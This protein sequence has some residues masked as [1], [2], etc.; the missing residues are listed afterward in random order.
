MDFDLNLSEEAAEEASVMK[1][2]INEWFDTTNLQPK[3]ESNPN[4]KK[5]LL[6]ND[7]YIHRFLTAQNYDYDKAMNTLR[8]AIEWRLTFQ[9]VGIET[10]ATDSF[11]NVMDML[12][13][14]Y[15]GHDQFNRPV[16]F[17]NFKHW[18]RCHRNMEE[19]HRCCAYMM[20]RVEEFLRPPTYQVVVIFD[21]D[22]FSI[23]NLDYPLLHFV[24]QIQHFYPDHLATA[25]I[26]RAPW[27][28]STTWKCI[29]KLIDPN[30]L[31]KIDFVDVSKLQCL[32]PGVYQQLEDLLKENNLERSCC[33]KQVI[34]RLM[35]NKITSS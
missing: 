30:T 24:V 19:A 3:L 31:S 34:H 13:L 33:V 1:K 11:E 26:I 28:F 17:L 2:E 23:K 10:V 32:G 7:S 6:E 29:K 22:E 18:S 8:S 5:L 4:T 9:G 25:Y 12:L 16:F 20:N 15:H 21:M 14:Y 27:L 35:A